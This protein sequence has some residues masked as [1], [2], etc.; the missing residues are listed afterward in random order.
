MYKFID[1]H[2]MENH[3]QREASKNEHSVSAEPASCGDTQ[4]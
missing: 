3:A 4:N 1:C 2:I